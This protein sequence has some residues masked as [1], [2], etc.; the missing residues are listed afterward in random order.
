VYVVHLD[1]WDVLVFRER[2]ALVASKV[3]VEAMETRVTV[4][5]VVHK[6]FV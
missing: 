2:L 5:C 3:L 6:V 4:V 1:L